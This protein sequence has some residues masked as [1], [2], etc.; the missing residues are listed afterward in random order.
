MIKIIN[1]ERF[2][3]NKRAR[4]YAE[5]II[6]IIVFVLI[7]KTWA[8]GARHVP[9]GSMIGTIQ[10]GDNIFVNKFSYGLWLPFTEKKLM[11]SPVVKGDVVVFPFPEDPSVDFI[12]RVIAVGGDTIDIDGESVTVN[13]KLEQVG[14][15]YYDR[16]MY[17]IQYKNSFVVP[18]GKLWVMGDNRRNSKDSRFWGFVDEKTVKGKGSIVYWSHDP[19]SSIF[20]GYRFNRIANIL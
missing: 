7:F 3:K 10:V 18:H 20:S 6:F 1:L 16:F 9:T 14:F 15:Q 11:A 5:D 2:I 12:K 13:G 4:K 19:S 17:P 8:F